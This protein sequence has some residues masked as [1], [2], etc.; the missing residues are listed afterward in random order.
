MGIYADVR[1]LAEVLG[2]ERF[3][4]LD[5]GMSRFVNWARDATFSTSIQPPTLS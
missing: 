2:L 5:V 4:P 1:R 3:T